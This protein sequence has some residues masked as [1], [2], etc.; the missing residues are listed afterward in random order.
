MKGSGQIYV[1]LADFS[2]RKRTP[3]LTEKEA[4]WVGE[5][6]CTSWRR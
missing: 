5:A 2:P 1:F 6:I 4:V 3:I